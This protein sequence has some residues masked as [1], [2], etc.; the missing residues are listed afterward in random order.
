[1]FQYRV[2]K[3][4]PRLRDGS[5]AFLPDD[6]TSICDVGEAFGGVILTREAYRFVEDAYIETAITFLTEAGVPAL[7][8]VGVENRGGHT[9]APVEGSSVGVARLSPPMRGVLRAEYWCRFASDDAFVHFG[10]DYYMYVGVPVRCERA[11]QFA[12]R[13]GLFVEPFVSPYH[14]H[15]G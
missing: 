13:H 14:E 9:A 3:Y 10:Y 2:T 7:R 11:H 4:D 15:D 6:W 1:M 8:C 12:H 5:R